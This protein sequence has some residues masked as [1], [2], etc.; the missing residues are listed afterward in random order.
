MTHSTSSDRKLTG[1]VNVQGAGNDP[2]VVIVGLGMTG[3]SCVT[4]F[5]NKGITPVVVDSRELPPGE[6][7]LPS[8]VT[9][10]RGHLHP[11]VLLAARQ[12]ILSP[13]IALATPEIAAAIKAGV[14]VI[15]DIELFVREA[16][17]PIIAITG[18][19]GK[20]TVTTLVG[21]MAQAAGVK[22]AIGGNIGIPA[23]SLLDV[24][25]PY[26][27]YVLELSSF[28]LET[29]SSLRAAA[30]TVLNVSDDHLDR[31]PDF[32][33]YRQAKLSIYNNAACVITNRDDPLTLAD[34]EYT[35]SHHSFGMDG[36]DYGLI[37]DNETCYL[38]HQ[39]QPLISEDELKIKGTHNLMNALAAIALLDA[40]G[41]AREKS[42]AGLRQFGGLA[43]R[44]EFI[45]KVNG[46]TWINDTK[47][48]NVGATQAALAGLSTSV[49]GR[50][51]LIA[52]GEGKG[53]DFS[54]LSVPFTEMI[55]Q[56]YCFGKDRQALAALSDNT[57][58]VDDLA[59]AVEAI[60][61]IA[62]EQDW[63]LLSPA[64]ASLDMYPNYMARGD[65]FRALVEAL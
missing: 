50:L 30:A 65:H 18:S 6:D 16:K 60:S 64:C 61:K 9:L 52:G 13:G 17:A 29:T 34:S 51:F 23:L 10:Y 41:V 1:A 31:Y 15:G 56:I 36:D 21:E 22:V 49:K 28:Q 44:C 32:E 63:V 40:V 53:A 35:S 27:L 2:G 57:V 3:L 7:K 20:S 48:T 43:H 59:E 25:E 4:Y 33:A 37:T 54:P 24:S 12:I 55:S 19:N 26:E 8:S 5:L 45:R 11:E 47:A 58:I 14:E 38:A 62:T 42:F 46:V 39:G